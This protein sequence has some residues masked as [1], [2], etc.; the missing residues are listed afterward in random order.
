MS[1]VS[2]VSWSGRQLLISV[3]F[4]WL[5]WL[6]RRG[7]AKLSWAWQLWDCHSAADGLSVAV[8]S[9]KWQ[10]ASLGC[11]WLDKWI[12]KQTL[13]RRKS[14]VAAAVNICTALSTS[15]PSHSPR[16]S[17]CAAP[18]ASSWHLKASIK[19]QANYVEWGANLWIWNFFLERRHSFCPSIIYTV[20]PSPLFCLPNG[21]VCIKQWAWETG[22]ITHQTFQIQEGK[23]ANRDILQVSVGAG[24]KIYLSAVCAVS[25]GE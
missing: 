18:H 10:V 20:S 5:N 2:W 7:G 21:F 4:D 22:S 25:L 16:P 14:C 15:Y 8:A 17:S 3:L 13:V 19:R 12:K 24:R 23:I 6:C 11:A 9:G 1:W